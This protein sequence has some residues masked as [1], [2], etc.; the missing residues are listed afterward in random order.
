MIH[1][2]K[3]G[4]N[5]KKDGKDYTIKAVNE[6]DKAKHIDDGWVCSLSEVKAPAKR[7]RKT[8]KKVTND[9]DKK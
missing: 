7:K 2:Y 8:T 5:W 9:D 4:G 3:Q 6:K 1:L